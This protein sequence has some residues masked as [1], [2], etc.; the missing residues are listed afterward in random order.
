[1]GNWKKIRSLRP[2]SD[3]SRVRQAAQLQCLS[4]R[5]DGALHLASWLTA[6]GV[7]I[8]RLTISPT[9]GVIRVAF[10]PLLWRLFAGDCAWRERK[11]VGETL[12]YTWFAVRDG[13]RIEWE[14]IECLG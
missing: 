1:M 9:H 6:I 5:M 14:E 13:T 8:R 12:V 11:R 7:Q 10:T 2:D 3:A 4:R